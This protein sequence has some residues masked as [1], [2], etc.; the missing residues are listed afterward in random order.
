MNF[1]TLSKKLTQ[2]IV[3]VSTLNIMFLLFFPV[4]GH[5]QNVY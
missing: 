4:T 5:L 3:L 2:L 1:F